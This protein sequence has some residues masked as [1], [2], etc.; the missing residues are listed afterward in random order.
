MSAGVVAL[1]VGRA[2]AWLFP[3]PTDQRG[4]AIVE[5]TWLGILLLVP[6]VY[7]V[8]AVFD[9]QRGAFAATAASRT[10]ARAYALA[11]THAEGVRAAT[12]AAEL[13][14]ADQ[15]LEEPVDVR[16]LCRADLG[17]AERTGPDACRMPGAVIHV[18]VDSAVALPLMPEVLGGGQPTVALEAVHSVPYGQFREAR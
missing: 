13:A 16:V 5:L 3:R 18:R 12:T 8:L 17:G 4:S 15:G 10:A 1:A 6:V 14:F 7:V 2:R 9:A 11:D